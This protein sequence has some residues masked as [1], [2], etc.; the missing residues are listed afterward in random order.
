MSW[1]HMFLDVASCIPGVGTVAAVVNAGLYLAKGDYVSASLS[2]VAAIP[3]G[4]A[5]VAVGV[6]A[7]VK[8]AKA[9]KASKGAQNALKAIKGTKVG[10][11][12]INQ[13]KKIGKKLTGNSKRVA[14]QAVNKTPYSKTTVSKTIYKGAKKEIKKDTRKY[15]VKT[16][17]NLKKFL[18]QK[19]KL[20][21]QIQK[22]TGRTK[23]NFTNHGYGKQ[24][25]KDE[26]GFT[27][28]STSLGKKIHQ[29]YK[30][31]LADKISTFKEFELPSK[32]KVDFIDFEKKMIYELKPHNPKSVK[33]G[34]GQLEKYLK[35]VTELGKE[36]GKRIAAGG[37]LG[38]KERNYMGDWK[39]QLD[40]Y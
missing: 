28:S 2:A 32:K 40:T 3:L 30:K 22:I 12:I 27:K 16:E 17:K 23:P 37:K 7:G 36:Q 10:K 18:K 6:K 1:I 13:T 29:E 25:G 19:M 26:Y 20:E 21:A 39:V 35:E 24:L 15:K 33:L 34:K 4:G 38:P 31:D 11:T 8:I 14:Q 5:A 9:V